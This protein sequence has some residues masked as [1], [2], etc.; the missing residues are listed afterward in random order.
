MNVF[1][2]FEKEMSRERNLT[3]QEF[4]VFTTGSSLRLMRETVK[5]YRCNTCKECKEKGS[6]RCEGFPF[7]QFAFLNQVSYLRVKPQ[8]ADIIV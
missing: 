5:P 4:V 6:L 7:V 3:A 8:V 1:D 2:R